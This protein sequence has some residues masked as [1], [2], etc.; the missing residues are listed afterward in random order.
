MFSLKKNMILWLARV[1]QRYQ[2]FL[3]TLKVFSSIIWSVFVVSCFHYIHRDFFYHRYTSLSFYLPVNKCNEILKDKSSTILQGC[4]EDKSALKRKVAPWRAY[5]VLNF[6][7]II[8]L[9]CAIISTT[10]SSQNLL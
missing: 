9:I 10:V 7:D 3:Q 5:G 8:P 6:V 1:I 2:R 4:H